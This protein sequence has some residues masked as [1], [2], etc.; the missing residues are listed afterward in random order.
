MAVR[1]VARVRERLGIELD[2]HALFDCTTIARLAGRVREA[3]GAVAHERDASQFLELV[4]RMSDEEVEAILAKWDD[5]RPD[6]DSPKEQWAPVVARHQSM[7][8][9]AGA[10]GPEAARAGDLE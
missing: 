4:E 5:E 10:S 8:H 9:D 2:V 6:R 7:R 3:L 1:L